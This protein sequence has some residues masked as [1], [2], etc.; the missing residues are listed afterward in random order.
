M[1][2]THSVTLPQHGDTASAM[3]SVTLAGTYCYIAKHARFAIGVIMSWSYDVE[4][5]G[6]QNAVF[7]ARDVIMAVKHSRQTAW[8]S[9]C[10]TLQFKKVQARETNMLRMHGVNTSGNQLT[11]HI[12]LG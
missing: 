1:S 4:A 3:Y 8:H 12:L 11:C 10:L 2:K 9:A 7:L 6:A 5:C